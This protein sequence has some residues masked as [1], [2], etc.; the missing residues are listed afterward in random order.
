MTRL[1]QL[2]NALAEQGYDAFLA[3]VR[4][5]QLTF[6]DHPDPTSVFGGLPYLLI[7]PKA[8]VVFP[9]LWVSNACRDLLTRCEV[10]T[11]E[12][13][14]PPGHEQLVTYLKKSGIKKLAID[15][16][17][18]DVLETLSKEVS[19]MTIVS[20]A[21]TIRAMRRK[22]TPEEIEMLRK[23]AAIGD[24]GIDAAFSVVR[25]GMTPRDVE[26]EGVATMLKMGCERAV[27]AVVTGPSTQYLDSGTDYR[28]TIEVGDMIF[29]DISISYKGYLGDQTRAAIVGR[30]TPAQ[31]DLLEAV[32]QSFYQVRAAL[33]S[34]AR[35]QDVYAI[36]CRNMERKGWRKYFYHHISHGVGLG[37]SDAG[38]SINATSEDVLQEDDVISCEPGVYVPGVGG[39]RVEDIIHVTKDGP[40]PL[41]RT[42]IERIIPI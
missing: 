6:I 41:T 14:D 36:H 30:G 19:T 27:I 28:R 38:P 1:H 17:G 24:A 22:R 20:E 10:I 23:T 26:A 31:H 5:N 18:A 39:A 11:N 21:E 8:C 34:G 9:G 16:L 33:V 13:G 37:G 32:R 25:P 29:M 3:T 7:T 2:R 40:V 42:A 4:S 15:V 12:L 35:A